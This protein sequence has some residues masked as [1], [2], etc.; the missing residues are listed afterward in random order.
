MNGNNPMRLA[1]AVMDR[2]MMEANLEAT[3]WSQR[4][5]LVVVGGMDFAIPFPAG[6]DSEKFEA[7]AL[8]VAVLESAMVEMGLAVGTS[9][10][11]LGSLDPFEADILQFAGSCFQVNFAGRGWCPN[12]GA[13]D[14]RSLDLLEEALDT[15]S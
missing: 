11:R 15:P 5:E 9:Q 14:L 10:P 13:A 12:S 8:F 1:I 4:P 6:K 7:A 2:L 3:F